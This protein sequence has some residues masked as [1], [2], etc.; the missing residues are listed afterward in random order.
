MDDLSVHQALLNANHHKYV[1]YFGKIKTIDDKILIKI[2]S[3]KDIKGSILRLVT[4]CGNRNMFNIIECSNKKYFVE[5]TFPD[6]FKY[7]ENEGA[8]GDPVFDNVNSV[9]FTI[10]DFSQPLL[11]NL[12]AMCSI[13]GY[14]DVEWSIYK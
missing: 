9:T 2:G 4:K 13:G 11:I 8:F 1:V 14:D 7:I 5:C 10:T 6:G 3:T 12:E